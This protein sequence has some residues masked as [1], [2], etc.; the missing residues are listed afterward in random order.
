MSKSFI[1][2]ATMGSLL[3]IVA[4][5]AATVSAQGQSLSNHLRAKIPFDFVVGNKKFPAGEYFLGNAQITSDIVLAISSTNGVANTLTIP[6][7]IGTPTD[8]AKLIFH[9]Y[10]DQYF[11]FQVWQV[12]ATTGR[13]VPKSRAERDVEQKARLS[14]PVG[15]ANKGFVETVPI[16]AYAH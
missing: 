14:A 2:N 5:F 16:V 12:G 9:R 11:L 7:Q 15:A 4:M 8:T 10:G 6:V 1:R 13:A 3:M